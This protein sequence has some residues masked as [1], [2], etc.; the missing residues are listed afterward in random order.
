[1][2]AVLAQRLVTGLC[3]AAKARGAVLGRGGRGGIEQVTVLL[4]GTIAES[5]DCS[6]GGRLARWLI[7][8]SQEGSKAD[9][10][11]A[12]GKYAALKQARRRL[13]AGRNDLDRIAA[14]AG[15]RMLERND[16]CGRLRHQTVVPRR[17]R[18]SASQGVNGGGIEADRINALVLDQRNEMRHD[19]WSGLVRPAAAE[20]AFARTCCRS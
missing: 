11:I 13:A 10:R 14:D 4:H 15:R 6:L 8:E 17:R 7:G 19:V 16:S 2:A 9:L 12:V 18:H 5:V 20:R 3:A 1:M